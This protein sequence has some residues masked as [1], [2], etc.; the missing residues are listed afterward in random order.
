MRADSGHHRFVEFVYLR[1]FERTTTGI[2]SDLDIRALENELLENPEAGDVVAGTGGVRKARVARPGGG[3]SGGV[4]V[5]YLYVKV[6]QRIYMILA[7][8]KN[9]QANLTP[10]QKSAIR[11]LVA[12]LKNEG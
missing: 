2:L 4:R 11:K 3:K 5:V 10:D 6:K 9:V 12:E 7:F 1:F 8:P